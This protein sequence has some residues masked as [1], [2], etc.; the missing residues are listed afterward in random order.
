MPVVGELPDGT[1][2]PEVDLPIRTVPAL[3][4]DV[5]RIV[6]GSPQ[7]DTVIR[8]TAIRQLPDLRAVPQLY[9]PSFGPT[10][11]PDHLAVVV[12]PGS[13]LL[14]EPRGELLDGGAVPPVNLESPDQRVTA[15]GKP[16]PHHVSPIVELGGGIE[17]ALG[18]LTGGRA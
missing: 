8:G 15:R 18:K 1:A 7:G 12:H 16:Q 14:V 6:D 13:A 10:L 5:A 3:P 17:A 11:P 4:G 2:A 9:L